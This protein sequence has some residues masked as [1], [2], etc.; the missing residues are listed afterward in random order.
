MPLPNTVVG[1]HCAWE[2][3]LNTVSNRIPGKTQ[4]TWLVIAINQHKLVRYLFSCNIFRNNNGDPLPHSWG[5][6]RR[7]RLLQLQANEGED[8]GWTRRPGVESEDPEKHHHQHRLQLR[9]QGTSL[10]QQHHQRA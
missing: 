3:R 4:L 7:L 8:V 1:S 5:H 6:L 2:L 9:L 10:A